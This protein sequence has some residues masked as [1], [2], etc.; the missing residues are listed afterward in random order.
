MRDAKLNDEV[1]RRLN[2]EIMNLTLEPGLTVSVQKLASAF[3]VSR[4]PVR[5][6]VIR[7]QK[8]GLVDIY[9]QSGTVNFSIF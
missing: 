3:G 6:A 9:P 8:K 1:Y 5:E 4:T 2:N 7:L